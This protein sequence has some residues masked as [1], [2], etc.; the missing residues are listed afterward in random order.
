MLRQPLRDNIMPIV[1][2]F[3]SGNVNALRGLMGLGSM[4]YHNNSNC[5]EGNNIESHY[6]RAGTDNR[7][8]CMHCARLNAAGQ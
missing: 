1:L 5:T 3:H 8:L 4:V 6:W 2:P 7:P